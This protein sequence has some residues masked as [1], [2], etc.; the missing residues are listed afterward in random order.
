[1]PA[2]TA[3]ASPT[4]KRA[5][6]EGSLEEERANASKERSTKK[7]EVG[8]WGVSREREE[9]T[10]YPGETGHPGLEL[11]SSAVEAQALKYQKK[12]EPLTS[13]RG[14]VAGGVGRRVCILLVIGVV[15]WSARGAHGAVSDRYQ[16]API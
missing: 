8:E 4:L 3:C 16:M 1:M 7:G 5:A 15:W 12:T 11:T 2:S 10:Q 9:G 14:G 6:V 13:P